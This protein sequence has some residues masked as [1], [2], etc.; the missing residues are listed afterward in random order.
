MSTFFVFFVCSS[1][2]VFIPY[3]LFCGTSSKLEAGVGRG[4]PFRLS[5]P[6]S[7]YIVVDLSC[8]CFV[9]DFFGPDGCV[10]VR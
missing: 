10:M 2:N 8:S 1:F 7:L 4:L 6:W 9:C 5:L 3:V